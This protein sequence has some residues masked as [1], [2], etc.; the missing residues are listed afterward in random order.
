MGAWGKSP[1]DNDGAADWFGDLFEE[2]PLP[3]KV[4]A[5]LRLD[6]RLHHEKIRAA[7]ALLVML[8]RTYIWPVND[9][10]RHL[11]LAVVRM[12]ELREVYRELGG[13]DWVDVVDSEIAVLRARLANDPKQSQP[14]QPTSWARFWGR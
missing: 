4:E 5:I 8:G 13:D 1:W 2:L 3:A 12:E 7:A 9:L 6:A 10:N 14:P 11:E